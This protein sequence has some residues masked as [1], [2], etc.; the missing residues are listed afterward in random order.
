MPSSSSLE[1][2]DELLNSTVFTDYR[3]FEGKINLDQPCRELSNKISIAFWSFSD[4]PGRLDMRE[5]QGVLRKN[6]P[7]RAS[8][9][10]AV[11]AGS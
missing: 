2:S 6:F 8:A 7:G 10:A 4:L 11:A 1:D 9:A 5:L 3:A